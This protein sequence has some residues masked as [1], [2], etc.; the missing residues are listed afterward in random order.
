MENETDLDI[1]IRVFEQDIERLENE[2]TEIEKTI[3][4][5]KADLTEYYK[6]RENK[7]ETSNS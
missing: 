7:N 1:V 2:K 5:R 6:M 4:R 3:K